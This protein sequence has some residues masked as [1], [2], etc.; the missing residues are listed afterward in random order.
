MAVWL[1]FE[2]ND[3][4]TRYEVPLTLNGFLGSHFI[5]MCGTGWN[6]SLSPN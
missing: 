6:I 4:K 3:V 1:V 5:I 2:A